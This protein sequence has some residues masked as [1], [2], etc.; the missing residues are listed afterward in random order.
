ME[1]RNCCEVIDQMVEEIPKDQTKLLKDL[2]W[3]R[4][5]ASFK[6]PEENLQW[7]R[8]MGTL[9]KNLPEPKEEWEFKILSIFT[10]KP[11]KELKEVFKVMKQ[12]KDN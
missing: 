1:R 10:T 12:I 6:A 7:Q 4:E 11:I 3:N 8:T 9:Q 2:E 5:D